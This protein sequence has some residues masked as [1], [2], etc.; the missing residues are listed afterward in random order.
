M[1][2]R[3]LN[4]IALDKAT[5][6]EKQ[7]LKEMLDLAQSSTLSAL[8]RV[9]HRRDFGRKVKANFWYLTDF[10]VTCLPDM[11]PL[12]AE[13]N[14]YF[15]ASPVGSPKETKRTPK[16]ASPKEDEITKEDTN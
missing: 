16:A 10:C 13:A 3:I 6:A 8:E 7:Q 5:S 2:V 12:M 11:K 4:T 15:A 9:T 14:A 1:K